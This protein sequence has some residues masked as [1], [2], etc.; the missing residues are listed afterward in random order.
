MPRAY[1]YYLPGHV[2]YITHRGHQQE[3]FLKFAG[4]Q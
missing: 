2:W 3:F 4:E 1:R